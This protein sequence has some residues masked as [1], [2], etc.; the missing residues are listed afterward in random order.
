MGATATE[1]DRL[2][3][4]KD[5]RTWA[6]ELG[7]SRAAAQGRHRFTQNPNIPTNP[8]PGFTVLCDFH[9]GYI[10]VSQHLPLRE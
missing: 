6:R 7:W 2:E 9:W 8:I 4:S 3:A 5:Y 10:L 1:S